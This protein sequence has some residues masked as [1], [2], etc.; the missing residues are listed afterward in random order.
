CHDHKFDPV[1]MADYYG[2]YGIFASTR[3]AYAGSEEFSSM[4]KYREGFVP[5]VPWPQAEPA[6]KD[7]HERLRL[8]PAQIAHLEKDGPLAKHAADLNKRIAE[9]TKELQA[10]QREN[11][12]DRSR[13]RQRLRDVL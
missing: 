12:H 3:F 4:K 7:Y 10:L 8:L 5:L 6:L 2:L 9:K 11:N 1:T 13:S